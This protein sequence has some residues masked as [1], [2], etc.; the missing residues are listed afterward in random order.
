MAQPVVRAVVGIFSGIVVLVIALVAYAVYAE[1]SA[2]RRAK[3]FCQSVQ[4][5]EN[6]NG[7][8]ERAKAEGADERQTRWFTPMDEDRWLPVTFTGFT[9]LSRHI[10]SIKATNTVKSAMYVYLD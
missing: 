7:L 8:L 9:P 10:C 5:G 2:E 3:N 4:V 1:S 6:A